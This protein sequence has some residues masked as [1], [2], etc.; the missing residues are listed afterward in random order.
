[1]GAICE[2][3]DDRLISK[4]LLPPRS[5]DLSYDFLSLGQPEGK[6]V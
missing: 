2:V 1:M 3:F 4:G 5:P 6:S